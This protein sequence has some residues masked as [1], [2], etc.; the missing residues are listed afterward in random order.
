MK[1]E[2]DDRIVIDNNFSPFHGLPGNVIGFDGDEVEICFD[3]GLCEW[4]PENWVEFIDR[5]PN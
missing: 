3:N 2:Q 4:L 1:L 5:Y